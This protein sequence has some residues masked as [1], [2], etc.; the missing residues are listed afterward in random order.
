MFEVNVVDLRLD[1]LRSV[2]KK[3]A[4]RRRKKACSLYFLKFA[5]HILPAKPRKFSL[6][7]VLVTERV[8][9]RKVALLYLQVAPQS[10]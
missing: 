7:R 9:H 2:A 10:F 1:V 4:C 5:M 3:H 8:F 6:K